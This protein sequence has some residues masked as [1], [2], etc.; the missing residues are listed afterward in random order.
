M[1]K[2]ADQEGTYGIWFNARALR[3]LE[4]PFRHRLRPRQD[5]WE[6]LVHETGKLTARFADGSD[7]RIDVAEGD[8]LLGGRNELYLSLR[9]RGSAE[10]KNGE[11]RHEQA[12][13]HEETQAGQEGD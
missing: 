8:Q 13:D 10:E 2:E 11:R 9:P 5:G 7:E 6:L 3:L 1:A 4:F 12:G